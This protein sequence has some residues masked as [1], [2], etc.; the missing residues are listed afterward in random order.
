MFQGVKGWGFG[1]GLGLL[2]SLPATAQAPAPVPAAGLKI[3]VV[4]I[5]QVL[6]GYKK[7]DIL[8]KEI[9]TRVKSVE[10]QME[11][12]RSQIKELEEKLTSELVKNDQGMRDKLEIDL[13]KLKPDLEVQTRWRNIVNTRESTKAMRELFDDI[14]VAVDEV[15]K[16]EGVDLVFQVVPP[17]PQGKGDVMEE[18]VRR[19][20][21]FFRKET[22]IELSDKV[23]RQVNENLEKQPKK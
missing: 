5:P 11:A 1:V 3:A 18:I 13:A 2:A 16:R 7:R 8:Q 21:L 20:L 17:N 9:E 6:Q 12:L 19:P 14:K 10:I 22:V 4:D 15:A 23:S